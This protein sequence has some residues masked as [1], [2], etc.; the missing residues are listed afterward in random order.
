[1][2]NITISDLAKYQNSENENFLTDLLDEEGSDL[3]MANI[4]GGRDAGSSNSD[5]III[6]LSDGT[7]IIIVA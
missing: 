2:A 1:M 3:L 7:V 4:I 6:I 5:V